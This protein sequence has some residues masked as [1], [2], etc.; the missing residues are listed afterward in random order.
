M[1]HIDLRYVSTDILIKEL[2]QREGVEITIVDP[3]ENEDIKVNGPAI[4]LIVRD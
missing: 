2:E 3:Y 4:V 1:E